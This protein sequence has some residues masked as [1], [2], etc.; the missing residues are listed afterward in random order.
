MKKPILLLI[1]LFGISNLYAQNIFI[2]TAKNFTNYDYRVDNAVTASSLDYRAG[3]GSFY[4]IGYSPI[5]QDNKL[6]YQISLT[7][8][9]FNAA[10][11]KDI[12]SYSWRTRYAGLQNIADYSIL[13]FD[14]RISLSIIAGV[15]LGQII[16][17]EQFINTQY[18]DISDSKEFKGVLLQG[19]VGLNANF[20]VSRQVTYSVGCNYSKAYN[21]VLDSESSQLTMNTFQINFGLH[22][23]IN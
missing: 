18:Y 3:S 8:N 7:Y 15:N 14:N 21:N 19:I 12:S 17:G 11:S 9:E 1:A 13:G 2:R 20:D 23:H 10:A 4:E 6:T 16:S 5:S 22:Y